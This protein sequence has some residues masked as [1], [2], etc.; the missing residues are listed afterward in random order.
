MSSSFIGSLFPLL[1]DQYHEI[2]SP[3]VRRYNCIA[4][5][6]CDSHRFWWPDAEGNAYWPEGITREETLASFVAAYQTLG[7][8]LCADGTL[9]EGIQKIAI[10]GRIENGM[11]MPTHASRQLSSGLWTSKMGKAEDISHAS[12][13][14]LTGPLYGSV[15]CFMYRVRPTSDPSPL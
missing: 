5:A 3:P 12:P 13:D 4:W 1:T 2:T 9:S 6:A 14:H 7:Y 10:Y 15:A 8:E 11:L